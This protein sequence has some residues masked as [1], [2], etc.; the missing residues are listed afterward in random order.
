M[1]NE[2]TPEK[3]KAIKEGLIKATIFKMAAN[4]LGITDEELMEMAQYLAKKR[5]EKGGGENA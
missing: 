4:D 2:L 3:I 5:K 1:S